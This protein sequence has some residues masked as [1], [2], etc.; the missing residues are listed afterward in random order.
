MPF[1]KQHPCL[2]CEIVSMYLTQELNKA[3][4]QVIRSFDLQSAREVHTSCVCAHHGTTVC[5]CQMI[6]LLVYL[7]SGEPHTLIVHG[8]DGTSH[9]GWGNEPSA[10]DEK[11][12]LTIFKDVFA[13]INNS[14]KNEI[15]AGI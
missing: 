9:L 7:P 1:Y 10:Q 8:R 15:D 14:K 4:Y 3:G 13:Q 12:M 11:I 2:N 6:V 5:D